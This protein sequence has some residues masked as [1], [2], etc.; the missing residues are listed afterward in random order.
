M[1]DA[2]PKNIEAL[3]TRL[4]VGQQW[5]AKEHQRRVVGDPQAATDERFSRALAGWDAL[6]RV[7]RCARPRGCIWGPGRSCPGDAVGVCDSC[8]AHPKLVPEV[9]NAPG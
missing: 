9:E 4:Q 1:A 5:L 7:Y 8:V 6:E 2:S 3:R